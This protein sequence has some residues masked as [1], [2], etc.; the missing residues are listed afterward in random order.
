MAVPNSS[1]PHRARKLCFNA[2]NGSPW[3]GQGVPLDQQI[4]AAASAG[5]AAVSL[6]RYTVEAFLGGGGTVADIRR[7]LG[8]AQIDCGAITAA[9]MIGADPTAVD[10]IR[11]ASAWASEVNAPFVQINV[12]CAGS[13][14]RTQ[15]EAACD[16]MH[17]GPRLAIEY[18]PFTP[19]ARVRDAVALVTQVGRERAGVLI[20]VWHHERGPDGWA[21]LATVPADAIAYVEF[22]DGLPLG[23]DLTEDTMQRRAMPGQGEFNLHQFV[24]AIDAIGFD[25]MVSVEVL[26]AEWR[27]KSMDA[28]AA[29]AYRTS[30]PYWEGPSDNRQPTSPRAFHSKS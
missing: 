15:L 12:G 27:T 13:D 8:E 14:Q 28:F 30:A 25:G 19:L 6:D 24:D 20:D 1:I 4:A 11:L 21:N 17:E 9:G 22:D 16:A 10:A 7:L 29:E 2:F 3:T 5:F 23:P 26:N 18:M